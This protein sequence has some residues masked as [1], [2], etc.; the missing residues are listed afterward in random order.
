MRLFKVLAARGGAVSVEL[1]YHDKG[2]L[3][4]G[5]NADA[6]HANGNGHP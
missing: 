6:P 3:S 5:G 1:I 4:R 2:E